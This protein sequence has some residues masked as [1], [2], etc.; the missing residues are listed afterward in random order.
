M[1]WAAKYIGLP[2]LDHGRDF[3]GV[4]CWGLVRLVLKHEKGIDV[5]SYGD[6]SALDLQTVANTVKREAFA[7]P[8]VAVMPNAIEPFDVAVMYR[9]RD[10]IHVGIM[11]TDKHVL[12]IEEKI[13]AVMVPVSHATIVFRYPRFFRHQ[14]LVNERAA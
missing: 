12:H 6:T 5:P 13:S 3:N 7:Y 1:I 2:F 10:P 9:R 14:R 8:W 11:V 4:D